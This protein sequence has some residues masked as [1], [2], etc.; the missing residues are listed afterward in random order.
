MST[1]E[2]NNTLG[3]PLT[4]PQHVAPFGN[5]GVGSLRVGTAG[6]FGSFFVLSF[7][8]A[9]LLYLDLELYGFILL[10]ATWILIP[11][12]AMTDHVR[13]D[14]K[15]L[16]RDGIVPRF[17]R[18]LNRSRYWLRLS[19]IEQVDTQTVR[20]LRRGGR[21]MYR[22]ST[23]FRGK[24]TAITLTSGGEA[25]RRLVRSILV[26]IPTDVMDGRSLELREYL[27]TSSALRKTTGQND[28]PSIDVLESAFQKQRRRRKK[29]IVEEQYDHEKALSLRSLA[30]S[31]KL[32][33]SLP[34][35]LEAFRRAALAAPPDGWF[36]LE[37]SRC[38]QAFAAVERDEK[39]FRRSQAMMRLAEKRAGTDADL[40]ARI[41]ET[42]VQIG[43]WRRAAR[44]FKRSTEVVGE[45]FLALRGLAE[46][47]LREG[48][49]AHVI[50]NFSAANRLADTPSLRRWTSAE[51]E[52]FTRIN[53]DDE[54][55]ELEVSRVNLFDS[56]DRWQRRFFRTSLVGFPTI[57]IGLILDSSLVTNTGWAISFISVCGWLLTGFGKRTLERRI[58]FEVFSADEN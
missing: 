25:Y 1:N 10:F 20:S 16:L 9:F 29:G 33:G 49:I 7:I 5:D 6:Y 12:F 50:H 41:G 37:F 2:Q 8:S 34:Q 44:V 39:I 26:R 47:A 43:D 18:I 40:M 21:V 48:K 52:Y 14:G 31:L 15:R 28:I 27:L 4:E 42:Y 51:V 58:P 22:Y 17:W 19:D 23:T 24:G 35:S 38:L 32:S 55:M 36:L 53:S 13:F 45:T 11:V 54:Y 30:N 3:E 46:V 57:L 56:L